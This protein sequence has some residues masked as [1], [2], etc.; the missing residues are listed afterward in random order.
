MEDK[1]G[2]LSFRIVGRAQL[3]FLPYQPKKATKLLFVKRA[4]D[5]FYRRRVRPRIRYASG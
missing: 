4:H 1:V 5:S 3:Q 2:K